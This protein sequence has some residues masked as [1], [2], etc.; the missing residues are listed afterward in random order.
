MVVVHQRH[1]MGF[2]VCRYVSVAYGP[3]GADKPLTVVS[4]GLIN[5]AYCY[6]GLDSS[7]HLA[8]D[9]LR[10]ARDIP[11]ALICTVLTS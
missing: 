8:E 2:R 9:S 10:P 6:L 3:Q 7:T 4:T 1:W 11:I 5:P